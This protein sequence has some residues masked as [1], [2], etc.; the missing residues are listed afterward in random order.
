MPPS[1]C[2]CVCLCD[3]VCVCVCVCVH[4]CVCFCVCVSCMDVQAKSPFVTPRLQPALPIFQWKIDFSLL[5]SLVT[6]TG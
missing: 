1:L 3:S 4:V 2:V 6:F 5:N